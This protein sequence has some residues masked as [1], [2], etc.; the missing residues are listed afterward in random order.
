ML[1]GKKHIICKMDSPR[2]FAG[3]QYP[4]QVQHSRVAGAI[5]MLLTQRSEKMV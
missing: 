3:Q 2:Q 1:I 5:D 4:G